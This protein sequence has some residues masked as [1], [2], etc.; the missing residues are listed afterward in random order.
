MFFVNSAEVQ[1]RHNKADDAKEEYQL[2]L[3]KLALSYDNDNK[4][5][6]APTEQ[7]FAQT[8]LVNELKTK[9]IDVIWVGTSKDYENE[10][11]PVRVP[12]YKGLL[13]HRI[14][15]IRQSDQSRFSTI[16]SFDDLKQFKAGQGRS[17]SDT[18]ILQ[19]AGIPVATT[20]KYRNLFPMLEGGRFDYFP[21]GVHEPWSE[22]KRFAY[23]NLEVENSILLV[24]P[25]PA[26]LFVNKDNTHLHAKIESGLMQAVADGSFDKY[27]FNHP[28]IK[29]VLLKS[30]IKN[31]KVFRISNP[32]LSKETPF[33]DEKLWL[34]LSDL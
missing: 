10:L 12:L 28:M 25:L 19:S 23:R 26:Y 11:L 2:G 17:W 1:I 4:Y 29:D 32:N 3:L 13:G 31:R 14:F 21:R 33:E 9:G 27:F 24:Y 8:K 22:V 7:Y 18:K 20:F 30:N 15:I 34:K 5:I 16:D 6:Y